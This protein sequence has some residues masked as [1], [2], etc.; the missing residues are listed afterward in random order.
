ME[1]IVMVDSTKDII[2]RFDTYEEA[3]RVACDF[4][5]RYEQAVIVEV[6]E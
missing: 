4:T 1:W 5:K 2:D 3:F 6:E